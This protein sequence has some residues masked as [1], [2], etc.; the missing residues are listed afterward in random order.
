MVRAVPGHGDDGGTTRVP[1]G[2]RFK[3]LARTLVQALVLELAV[4]AFFGPILRGAAATL[5]QPIDRQGDATLD[6]S[7]ESPCGTFL[8]R[9][10]LRLLYRRG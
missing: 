7:Q 9:R 10:G 2:A 1:S 6:T 3:L 8:V 5:G 4:E